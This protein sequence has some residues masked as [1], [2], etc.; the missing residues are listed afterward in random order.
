M[1]CGRHE[2][3]LYLAQRLH[4]DSPNTSHPLFAKMSPRAQLS[5]GLSADD[6][7]RVEYEHEK[8]E[9]TSLREAVPSPRKLFRRLRVGPLQRP[10]HGSTMGQWATNFQH[11]TRGSPMNANIAPKSTLEQKSQRSTSSQHLQEEQSAQLEETIRES[12]VELPLSKPDVHRPSVIQSTALSDGSE[13]P[14]ELEV[15]GSDRVASQPVLQKVQAEMTETPDQHEAG[16]SSSNPKSTTNFGNFRDPTYLQA[17]S[18]SN[19]GKT[20]VLQ[21]MDGINNNR[22]ERVEHRAPLVFES[23]V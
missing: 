11:Q 18:G 8:D 7:L 1:R 3:Y 9:R 16:P 19:N 6:P 21:W 4:Q 2:P 14:K 13:V 17:T 20:A 12:T 10:F 5:G 22:S 15:R 23:E